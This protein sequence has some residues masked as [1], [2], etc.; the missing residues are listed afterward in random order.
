QDPVT[1]VFA[2]KVEVVEPIGHEIYL[3][4]T[5]GTSE[6]IARVSPDTM[7]KTG[8]AIKLAASVDKLH[9]FDPQTERAIGL[10]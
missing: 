4:V 7:Y 2:A 1:S 10:P 8:Q 9:A 3:D 6:I 5:V